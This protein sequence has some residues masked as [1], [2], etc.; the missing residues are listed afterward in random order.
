MAKTH[1]LSASISRS[2]A[3]FPTSGMF[4]CMH[5]PYAAICVAV[6]GM[7]RVR[8]VGKIAARDRIAGRHRGSGRGARGETGERAALRIFPGRTIGP[9]R[10]EAVLRRSA[11]LSD[12]LAPGFARDVALMTRRSFD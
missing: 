1:A 4:S 11:T 8:S 3:P 9:H 2:H 7:E 10:E 5:A 12:A 6:R